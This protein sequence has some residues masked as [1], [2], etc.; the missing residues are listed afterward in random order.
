MAEI[1]TA[2]GLI[3]EDTVVGTG[4]E[5]VA[6]KKVSVHY[7]GWLTNGQPFDSSKQRNE[8]FQFIL[9]GRQVIAGWDE[10]VQGMKI[11]GT[12]KLTIPPQLGYGARG[13]G[14][15]IPPNATLIFEV[16]L[17]AIL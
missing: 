12:R 13:A 15:V 17:L 8:A 5:A 11:G 6:G 7:S 9:G 3:Y 1:T 14:G 16:E 4:A 10:G 2:S